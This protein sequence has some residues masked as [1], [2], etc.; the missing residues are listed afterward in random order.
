MR[1]SA[2]HG[3][4]VL[5]FLIGHECEALGVAG[6]V[7]EMDLRFHEL[8]R[9]S[10]NTLTSPVEDPWFSASR[11]GKTRELQESCKSALTGPN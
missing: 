5:N 10:A 6:D 2:V 9:D 7:I 3:R 4:G 11:K 1:L 8:G